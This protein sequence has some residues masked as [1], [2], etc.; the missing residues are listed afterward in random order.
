MKF[1]EDIKDFLE[2]PEENLE[3]FLENKFIIWINSNEFYEDIVIY[4][5]YFLNE[6]NK[7]IYEIKRK[8]EKKDEIILKNKEKDLT[9]PYNWD[10]KN[11]DLILNSINNFIKEKYKILWF[12]ESIWDNTL[13]FIVL[14]NSEIE[15]LKNEFWE[16]FFNF[17][18]SEL[19]EKMFDLEIKEISKILKERKI[20]KNNFN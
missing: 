16:E 6:F 17:Y 11:R 15:E 4:I 18:F 10:K 19:E 13:W 8:D 14:K 9:I 3:F 2:N 20:L 7:I 5:N 12:K 1:L